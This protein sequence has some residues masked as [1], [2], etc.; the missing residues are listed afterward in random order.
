MEVLNIIGLN[1]H[2]FLNR[3]M[4]EIDLIRND[5]KTGL[6]RYKRPQESQNEQRYLNNYRV[7]V[8]VVV[9][10]YHPEIIE[11]NNKDQSYE[12]KAC[13]LLVFENWLGN[14][15]EDLVYRVQAEEDYLR[16]STLR[17]WRLVDV[18]GFFNGNGYYRPASNLEIE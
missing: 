16:L 10:A 14:P 18:D 15:S 1:G 5:Y 12:K 9:K 2:R 6:L 4:E 8:R 17:F 3:P 13:H 7:L 11:L